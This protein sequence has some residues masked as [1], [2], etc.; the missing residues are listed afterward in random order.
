M[1]SE[2]KS[3]EENVLCKQYKMQIILF[4]NLFNNK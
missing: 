1:V 2:K 3:W 4:L